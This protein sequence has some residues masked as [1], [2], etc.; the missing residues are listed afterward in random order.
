MKALHVVLGLVL[1]LALVAAF[2]VFAWRSSIAPLDRPPPTGFD[3]ALMAKGAELAKIANCNVCHTAEGGAPYAGGRPLKTPYGTIYSTNITPEPVTGIGRWPEAAFVRAMREGVDR[4]GRHLYPAFPYDHFTRMPDADIQALYAFIMSREPVRA[5][6]PANELFFPFNIRMLI[7]GWKAMYFRAAEFLPDPG[8]GPEWNR[9]AYLVEGPAHCGACHT[10]RNVLGA[11]RKRRYLAGGESEGWHAPALNTDSPAPVPWTAET[12]FEYLRRGVADSHAVAAGPML[13]VVHN[14]ATV[15]QQEVQAIAAYVASYAAPATPERQQR[16][17]YSA[18]R[19]QNDATALA[20]GETAP[21][22]EGGDP[23]LQMG[24]VIYA[25]ACAGCH[26]GGRQSPSSAT[27][28]NLALASGLT[29]PTPANLIRIVLDGIA[30]PEGEAGRWMPG[31]A[32]ALTDEQVVALVRFLRT[33]VARATP[34]RDVE[35]ELRKV[36]RERVRRVAQAVT[37]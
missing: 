3:A 7:A 30:P 17:E 35:S 4:H 11:E 37:K 1:A 31:F 21:A 10:P 15:S 32:G 5:E 26:D 34:W 16:S 14:L 27:A 13:P 28:L 2:V 36:H 19:A 8:Q 33:D 9:G 12:L 18:A 24:R 6:V 23:A 29:L 20:T 25:G 22:V